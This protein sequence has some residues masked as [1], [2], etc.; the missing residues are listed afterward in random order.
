MHKVSLIMITDGRKEYITQTIAGFKVATDYPFIEKIII[1][2]SGDI[3]Y[4]H[5]L[6]N[7]FP[8]FKVVS[9]NQRQGLA[10]AIQ[11]AWSSFSNE[12]EYIFHLEDDFLFIEKPQI[13]LMISLL[14][15]N[16]HLVQMALV[17]NPVNPPEEAVGGFVFQHLQDY[18]QRDGFF[19]HS[20][21]FTLNPSIY[22]VSTAK[23]GWPVRGNEPDF[24]SKILSLNKDHR[25]GYF[26]NIYDPPKVFHIGHKRTPQWRL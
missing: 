24:T 20:R 11:T 6:I 10:S 15:N 25:F 19:E 18:S 26:G 12:A 1:N 17:R 4:N 16:Q 9:H 3:D 13:D 2:D 21:L 8:D 22:P 5:F 7:N 14:K 23:V